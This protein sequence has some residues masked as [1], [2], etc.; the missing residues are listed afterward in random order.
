L[1]GFQGPESRSSH[2]IVALRADSCGPIRAKTAVLSESG[3]ESGPS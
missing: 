2:E 3:A 1:Q